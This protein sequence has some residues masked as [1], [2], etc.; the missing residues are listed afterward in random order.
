MPNNRVWQSKE[1]GG[2][3]LPPPNWLVELRR[4]GRGRAGNSVRGFWFG[5]AAAEA[6]SW[7]ARAEPRHAAPP[8]LGTPHYGNTGL[9]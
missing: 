8:S 7:N 1:A 9:Q 3:K 4:R 2:K 6:E 5:R